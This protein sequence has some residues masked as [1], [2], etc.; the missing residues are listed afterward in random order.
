MTVA[1][2]QRLPKERQSSLA[3]GLNQLGAA[4]LLLLVAD[5][6]EWEGGRPKGRQIEPALKKAAA[7]VGTVVNCES[8]QGAGLRTRAVEMFKEWGVA[9]DGPVLDALAEYAATVSANGGSGAVASLTRECEK[10]RSY[11]GEEGRV[12]MAAVDALL[13]QVAQENIFRLLDSVG[14]RNAR[15]AL[16]QVDRAA[17]CR[18]KA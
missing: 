11:V 18:G 1:S 7:A 3:E 2:V 4:S 6:P 10:L 12:T 13:P 14:A 16:E 17:Q 9:V 15:L 8:P 5:A